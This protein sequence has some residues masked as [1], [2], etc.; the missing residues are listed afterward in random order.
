[1][2]DMAVAAVCCEEPSLRRTLDW[3]ASKQR[4]LGH[5]DWINL[6]LTIVASADICPRLAHVNK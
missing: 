2:V 1:M 6:D 3:S 4:R 5:R